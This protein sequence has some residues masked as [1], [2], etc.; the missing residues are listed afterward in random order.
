M[1]RVIEIPIVFLILLLTTSCL[2]LSAD[3][4]ILDSQSYSLTLNYSV[5]SDFA[6]IKYLASNQ[7][8][9]ILPLTEQE[10]LD[11]TASHNGVI[12]QVDSF[13]RIEQ[14]DRIIIGAVLTFENVDILEDLLSCQVALEGENPYD[15][16]FSFDRGGE[17]SQ[18][19]VTYINGYCANESINMTLTGPSGAQVSG[20]WPL[21]ELLL[22][23]QAP[24]ISIGWEE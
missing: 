11:F 7:S 10:Y 17:P 1:K 19:A 13:S 8:V 5:R 4:T 15:L 9:M 6:R 2:S 12:F 16:T 21:R 22:E 23:P 20:E 3:L 18:E 24:S 14:G